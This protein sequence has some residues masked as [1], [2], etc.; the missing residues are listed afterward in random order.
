MVS[1]N[2]ESLNC[3]RNR[4][5]ERFVPALTF[6]LLQAES[7]SDL[8]NVSTLWFMVRWGKMPTLRTIMYLH[9]NCKIFIS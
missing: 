6:N 2:T 8:G 9:L 5:A 1:S 3:V 4:Y 7:Y